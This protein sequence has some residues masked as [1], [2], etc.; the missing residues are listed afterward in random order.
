MATAT[1]R[2]TVTADGLP[3][4]DQQLPLAVT[5]SLSAPV[6]QAATVTLANGANTLTKPTGATLF[7]G[8]PPTANGTKIVLKGV[9]GDTGIDG[10]A[11]RPFLLA[12]DSAE[13]QVV[14]SVGADVAG[15][16]YYWL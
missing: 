9:T 7:I 1:A 2:L 15:F 11:A 13:T 6:L 10:A 12:L 3:G 8:L 4:I 14:L 16:T 5:W